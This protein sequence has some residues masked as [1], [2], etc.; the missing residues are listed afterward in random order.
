MKRLLAATFLASM[1]LFF[2]GFI[3][4]TVLEPALGIMQTAPD[5]AAVAAS[6]A[7]QLKTEGTYFIPSDTGD[8]ADFGSRHQAGPLVTV[9]FRPQGA[10][11]MAPSTFAA[12]FLHMWVSV[13]LM[14]LLLRWIARYLDSYGQRVRF[15]TWVGAISAI[16][17]NLGRPIWYFQPWDYHILQAAYG[18]TSWLGVGLILAWFLHGDT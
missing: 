16:F 4:W 3:F 8:L 18:V 7:E 6:L 11:V 13:L 9:F 1:A 15:V 17:S 10:Q 5:E 12:G 14:A 2:W